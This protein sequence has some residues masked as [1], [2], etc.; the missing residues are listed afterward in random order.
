MKII[1]LVAPLDF[2]IHGNIARTP[3]QQLLRRVGAFK[4]VAFVSS[5]EPCGT[6]ADKN[7]K[8]WDWW[9]NSGEVVVMPAK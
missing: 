7:G 6:V 8:H 4:H 5:P 1:E 2:R 9:M 3:M